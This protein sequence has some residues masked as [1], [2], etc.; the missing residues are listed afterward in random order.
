MLVVRDEDSVSRYLDLIH[1][2]VVGRT[3]AEIAARGG[4]KRREYENVSCILSG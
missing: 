3:L 2:S 1:D 4:L